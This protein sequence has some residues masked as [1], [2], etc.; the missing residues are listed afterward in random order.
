MCDLTDCT[1]AHYLP[2]PDD[3]LTGLRE[4]LH[5]TDVRRRLDPAMQRGL[6]VRIDDVAADPRFGV[7][8]AVTEGMGSLLAVS[9]RAANGSTHGYLLV[10]HSDDADTSPTTT[11]PRSSSWPIT[12]GSPSTGT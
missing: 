8:A 3:R 12:S 2:F 7:G 10:R 6:V 5:L 4:P 9:V 11:K 1:D